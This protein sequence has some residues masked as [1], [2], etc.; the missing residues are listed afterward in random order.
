[1]LMDNQSSLYW[2]EYKQIYLQHTIASV[3]H[4]SASAAEDM[5]AIGSFARGPIRTLRIIERPWALD[6]MFVGF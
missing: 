3:R 1:M 2:E 5:P 4:N 6:G